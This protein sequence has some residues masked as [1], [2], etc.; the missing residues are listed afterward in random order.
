[1]MSKWRWDCHFWPT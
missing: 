1:V